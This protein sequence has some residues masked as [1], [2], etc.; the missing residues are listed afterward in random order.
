MHVSHSWLS[1]CPVWNAAVLQFAGD[2]AYVCCICHLQ[3]ALYPRKS[4][5]SHKETNDVKRTQ[6]LSFLHRETKAWQRLSDFP[7]VMPLESI[8]K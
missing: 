5:Y 6:I 7:G 8:W 4:Y 1:L 3:I 2:K